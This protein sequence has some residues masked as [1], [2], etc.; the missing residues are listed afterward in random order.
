MKKELV[1]SEQNSAFFDNWCINLLSWTGDI[2]YT[3]DICVSLF[4]FCFIWRLRVL[5]HRYL[6]KGL[7]VLDCVEVPILICYTYIANITSNTN[8]SLARNNYF[9]FAWDQFW[10]LSSVLSQA[11]HNLVASCS[12]DKIFASLISVTS[13]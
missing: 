8:A 6:V 7:A 2:I 9:L 1:S 11:K 3:F 4:K 5:Y 12:Q 13:S 10:E